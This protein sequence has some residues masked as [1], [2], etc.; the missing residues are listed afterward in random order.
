M[1]IVAGRTAA[2]RFAAISSPLKTPTRPLDLSG[3]CLRASSRASY[4]AFRTIATETFHRRSCAA[5]LLRQGQ[6][7]E[8][9]VVVQTRGYDHHPLICYKH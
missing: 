5:R 9:P 2:E 3:F 4:C 7:G 8:L 6:I 1:T